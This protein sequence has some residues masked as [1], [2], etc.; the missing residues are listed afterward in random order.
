MSNRYVVYIHYLNDEVIY[1]G[2][3][4]L[5]RATSTNGRSKDHHND[6]L[7]ENFKVEI[8]YETDNR[9]DAFEK[10]YSIGYEYK[11]KGLAKYFLHDM[12]GKNNPM[13]GTPLTSILNDEEIE[14]WKLKLR[15]KLK[16]ERNGY[17]TEVTVIAPFEE[18]DNYKSV[19]FKTLTEAKKYITNRYGFSGVAVDKA[20]I[21]KPY[22]P[23]K[24]TMK[25]YRKYQGLMVR[26]DLQLGKRR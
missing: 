5:E 20:M 18:D 17:R 1:V 25:K 19:S 10:E 14:K 12:R 16:G 13:S 2:S 21:D 9:K 24:G 11:E 22:E 4:S 6:M 8:V 7:K 3:G 15:D 26:R 23:K